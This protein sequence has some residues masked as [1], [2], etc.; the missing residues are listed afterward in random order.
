MGFINMKELRELTEVVRLYVLAARIETRK[1]EV[2]TVKD[3][4]VE[5]GSKIV[6]KSK[7][8]KQKNVF[9]GEGMRASLYAGRYKTTPAELARW[10]QAA[11]Q[12]MRQASEQAGEE[13]K[14]CC[15]MI[16][17]ASDAC[18]GSCNSNKVYMEVNDYERT[19]GGT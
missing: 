10:Q 16:R 7:K 5:F 17:R 13:V 18:P 8:K 15:G 11:W 1:E 12:A 2:P 4:K 6:R 9:G 3:N 19:R 14:Y